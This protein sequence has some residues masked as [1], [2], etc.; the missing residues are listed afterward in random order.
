M[1]EN[2]KVS[3]K[4]APAKKSGKKSLGFKVLI[5]VAAAIVLVIGIAIAYTVHLYSLMN[6]DDGKENKETTTLVSGFEDDVLYET[7]ENPEDIAHLPT[8]TID[9][10]KKEE[11][12]KVE[13]RH[14]EGVYN[15]LLL[16]LD[17]TEG[18]RLSD[19]IMIA[20]L[21][22]RNNA[23]KLTS[24]M[25]DIL[26]TIPG[27][28]PNKLNTPYQTGGISLLY[29]VFEENFKI[30]LDGYVAIDYYALTDA[31]D[32]LGGVE[33]FI[34]KDEAEF[35]NTSNYIEDVPSR[36]LLPGQ[37]QQV[38]GS[39]FVGYCRQRWTTADADFGRTKRQRYALNAL[40]E[41]FRK[42]SLDKILDAME[43]VLPYVTTDVKLNEMIS[44]AT[45]AVKSGLGEIKQSR[46]PLNN[47]QTEAQYKGM[48]VLD[49][50]FEANTK[51]LHEFIFG[52]YKE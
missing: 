33:L 17:T 44:L 3:R 9:T 2:K 8:V 23:I 43:T 12:T 52:D 6:Y 1:A 24:V 42:S 50:D 5:G 48:S 28:N 39:Q 27:H 35:L 29:Q 45:G 15:I 40:Y 46:I 11:D 49:I 13:A 7:V 31:V 34:S 41:K 22:T 38:N 16:G 32:A 25:R 51:A 18:K 47:A 19:T 10:N 36:N 20:T 37:K 30:K 14:E 26:V 4:K 21:D